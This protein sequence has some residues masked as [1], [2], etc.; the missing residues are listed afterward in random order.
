MVGAAAI[1][2]LAIVWASSGAGVR[3][4]LAL[5]AVAAFVMALFVGAF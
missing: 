5:G 3:W 4:V 1:I 2:G